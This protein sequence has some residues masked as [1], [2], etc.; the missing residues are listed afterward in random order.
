MLRKSDEITLH[1]RRTIGVDDQSIHCAP[2][3][4]QRFGKLTACGVP[5]DHAAALDQTPESS[6]TSR[7]IG[8]ASPGAIGLCH[9]ENGH[10]RVRAE[11]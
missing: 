7:N 9:R 4:S 2:L 6:Q 10:R 11:P 3:G 1:G 8:C 5:P